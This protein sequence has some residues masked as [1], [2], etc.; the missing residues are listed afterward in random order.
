MTGGKLLPKDLSFINGDYT[1]WFDGLK[2][3]LVLKASAS[4]SCKAGGPRDIPLNVQLATH[5]AAGN[6]FEHCQRSQRQCRGRLSFIVDSIRR[7]QTWSTLARVRSVASFVGL[8]PVDKRLQRLG[9]NSEKWGSRASLDLKANVLRTCREQIPQWKCITEVQ[10]EGDFFD[11]EAALQAF[12]KTGSWKQTSQGWKIRNMWRSPSLGPLKEGDPVILLWRM[13]L[14]K[15]DP[16][17]QAI[18][19]LWKVIWAFD[20]KV[21]PVSEMAHTTDTQGL[22]VSCM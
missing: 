1:V 17:T 15:A 3:M 2:A 21:L 16:I 19:L 9:T 5:Q 13:A 14:D 10:E 4:N 12:R 6:P 7:G 18:T 11:P 22:W 8:F 20:M